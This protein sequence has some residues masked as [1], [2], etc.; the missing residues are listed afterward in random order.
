MKK[1]ENIKRLKP[2]TFVVS[3]GKD[4]IQVNEWELREIQLEV[5]QGIR[6]HGQKV[7]ILEIPKDVDGNELYVT[8]TKSG[9]MSASLSS[10]EKMIDGVKHITSGYTAKQMRRFHE[11]NSLNK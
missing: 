4:S 3:D 9:L 6:E 10:I 5:K 8:I 2:L 7:S 1:L 11:L